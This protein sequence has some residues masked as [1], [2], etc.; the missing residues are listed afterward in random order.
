MASRSESLVAN[1]L[2]SAFNLVG[3]CI[4]AIATDIVDLAKEA[5]D[6]QCVTGMETTIFQQ[7]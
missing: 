7:Q 3:V 2:T 6:K 4:I 1:G 5:G